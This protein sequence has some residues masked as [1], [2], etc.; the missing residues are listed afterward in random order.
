M[1][2]ESLCL[3][4]SIYICHLRSLKLA[5]Y[6]W[7]DDQEVLEHRLAGGPAPARPKASLTLLLLSLFYSYIV[8]AIYLELD[9][10]SQKLNPIILF[11]LVILL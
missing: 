4:I 2:E 10:E 7:L 9:K 1:T 6:L 11:V 3:L 8:Q 5:A